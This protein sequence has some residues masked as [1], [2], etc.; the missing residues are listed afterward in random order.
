MKATDPWSLLRAG[1]VEEGL[2]PFVHAH[3]K[4]PTASHIMELGVA[5]LWVKRYDAAWD[6]FRSTN[7]A[8]PKH[9]SGF[10][11]MAG[12]AKWCMGECDEAARQWVAGLDVQFADTCGLGI[13]LPLLLFFA[14]V[15]K[16]ATYRRRVAE[17]LLKDKSEDSRITDWPGPIARWLLGQI[18][19]DELRNQSRGLDDADT[20]DRYWLARFYQ[21]V[22]QYGAGERSNFRETMGKLADT[23]SPEWSDETFFLARM[24][25]EEFFLARYE[26]ETEGQS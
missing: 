18:S 8:Y 17:K 4:E 9:G 19:D 1:K 14:S 15:V 23:S 13:R 5:Y 10:Y 11:G 2:R 25:S 21:N 7:A 6:H 20:C 12:V 16:P 26:A 3:S 22:F 24:W